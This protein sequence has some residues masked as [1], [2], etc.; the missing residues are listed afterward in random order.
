MR[1]SKLTYDQSKSKNENP[2]NFKKRDGSSFKRRDFK[3]SNKHKSF[4]RNTFKDK[5]Q[6]IKTYYKQPMRTFGY[7]DNLFNKKEETKRGP[8]QCW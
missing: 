6:T 2:Y 8:L 7:K 1:N 4:Q 5:Q 3:P